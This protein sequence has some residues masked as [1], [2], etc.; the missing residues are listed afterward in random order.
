[1]MLEVDKGKMRHIEDF[2]CLLSRVCLLAD[3]L[4]QGI[5]LSDQGRSLEGIKAHTDTPLADR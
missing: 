3:A 2:P 5:D 4:H 1:M